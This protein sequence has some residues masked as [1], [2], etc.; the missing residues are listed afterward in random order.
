MSNKYSSHGILLQMGD[1]GSPETFT[2]VAQVQDITP[3]NLTV[4]TEDTTTHDSGGWAEYSATLLDGGEVTFDILY[5]PADATHDNSTGLVAAL[6]AK[7]A[8]NFKVVFPDADTTTW[9]FAALVTN[10][11][12][13]GSVK[14]ML[15]ASVT[16]KITGAVTLA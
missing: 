13:S 5:D 12:P 10:F 3:P 8:K 11:Q 4:E 9:S 16:L 6:T 14:G 2:T 1:G 15:S 7:A